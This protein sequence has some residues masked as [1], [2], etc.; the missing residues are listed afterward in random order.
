MCIAFV[1]LSLSDFGRRLGVVVIWLLISS[2]GPFPFPVPTVFPFPKRF[3]DLLNVLV[4]L[5]SLVSLLPFVS[6]P[7]LLVSL[8]RHFVLVCEVLKTLG[9]WV[10]VGF[11]VWVV[12]GRVG[13]L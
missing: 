13:A 10:L 3:F 5:F 1:F 8:S 7:S 11:W 9:G 6:P 4:L 2:R 12:L